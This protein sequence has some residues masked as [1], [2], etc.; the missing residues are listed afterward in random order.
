V[1]V[2]S[3]AD[4]LQ[5]VTFKNTVQYN[6]RKFSVGHSRD[7]CWRSQSIN[8]ILSVLRPSS[9]YRAVVKGRVP[10]SLSLKKLARQKETKSKV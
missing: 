4:I 7:R 2:F 8:L 1:I 3:V 10:Q 5:A 6:Y 9:N